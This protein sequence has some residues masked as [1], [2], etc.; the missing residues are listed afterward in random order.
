[1]EFIF[2]NLVNVY[3]NFSYLYF[4]AGNYVAVFTQYVATITF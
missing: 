2:S 1:M 3:E 4:T